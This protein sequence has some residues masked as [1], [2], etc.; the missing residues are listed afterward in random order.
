MPLFGALICHIPGNPAWIFEQFDHKPCNVNGCGTGLRE[1]WRTVSSP[2]SAP[3]IISVY[4]PVLR[5]K[6]RRSY[7]N[8]LKLPRLKGSSRQ[9]TDHAPAAAEAFEI[10][11]FTQRL[12]QQPSVRTPGGKWLGGSDP[13]NPCCRRFPRSP[14]AAFGW[15][16]PN[17]I[18][19]CPSRERQGKG[20]QQRVIARTI[21]SRIPCTGSLPSPLHD[22]DRLW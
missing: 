8:C 7:R 20:F 4:Q 22:S 3:P 2:V 11:G 12:P 6:L 15:P 13:A 18:R 9:S 21:R 17:G 19:A 14:S 5:R 1:L 16:A 10:A